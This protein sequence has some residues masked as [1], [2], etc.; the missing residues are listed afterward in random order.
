MQFLLRKCLVRLGLPHDKLIAFRWA[1]PL[2]VRISDRLSTLLIAVRRGIA[3]TSS[4]VRSAKTSITLRTRVL[5]NSITVR[6]TWLQ[7][8]KVTLF[9]L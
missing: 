5:R 4:Q 2:D 6:D 1:A 3:P 8:L 9:T 7:G